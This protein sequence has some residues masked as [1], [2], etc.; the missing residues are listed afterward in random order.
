MAGLAARAARF[1]PVMGAPY[2]NQFTVFSLINSTIVLGMQGGNR[3][4]KEKY[5]FGG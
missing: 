3:G 2:C 4:I 5:H 1:E